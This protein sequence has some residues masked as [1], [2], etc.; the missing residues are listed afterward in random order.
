[1]TTRQQQA[2]R[3]R[4]ALYVRV[5][6]DKQSTRNQQ[7]ELEAVAKSAG[8]EIVG[9]YRD[10]GISG[11]KGREQRPA[12]HQLLKDATARKFDI[13]AAWSMDRLGRSLL[14]LLD[15]LKEMQDLD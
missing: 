3:K 12:F 8:W 5:S 2:N 15:F 13:V 9:V 1:M 4:V 14:G 11:A 6:T 7:R 10:Q